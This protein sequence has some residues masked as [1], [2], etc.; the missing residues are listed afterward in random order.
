VVSVTDAVFA[1]VREP[2][3]VEPISTLDAVHLAT[4]ELLGEPPPLM[5]GDPS[6]RKWPP[7]SALP[8]T[9]SAPI[10]RDGEQIAKLFRQSCQNI[11]FSFG[12]SSEIG[13][14]RSHSST[15]RSCSNRKMCTTAT[16]GASWSC[17]VTRDCV[18]TVLPSS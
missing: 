13:C 5:T 18:I 7:T 6:I 12:E 3:P 17:R 16:L 14:P 11:P 4:V 9:S 10:A 2:F 15:M 1:R 8:S